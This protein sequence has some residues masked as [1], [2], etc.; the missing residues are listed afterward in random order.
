MTVRQFAPPI[1]GFARPSGPFTRPF[2]RFTRPFRDRAPPICGFARPS[3]PF[4]RPFRDYTP[5]K[6]EHPRPHGP[7]APVTP[8]F[9]HRAATA[10]RRKGPDR[11]RPPRAVAPSGRNCRCRDYEEPIALRRRRLAGWAPATP[12]GRRPRTGGRRWF[13]AW[14]LVTERALADPMKHPA[15]Y[16]RSR[17]G[18]ESA[19]AGGRV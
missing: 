8:A 18:R 13:S 6:C 19:L 7:F 15:V 5:P 4:T 2:R 1:C 10:H 11:V 17:V 14:S 3:G 16:S 12:A 9:T